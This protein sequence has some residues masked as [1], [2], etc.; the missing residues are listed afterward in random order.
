M[1]VVTLTAVVVRAEG[2]PTGATPHVRQLTSTEGNCSYLSPQLS[3]DG[4]WVS[5]VSVCPTADG[6]GQHHQIVRIA[7]A[8]GQVQV[9]TPPDFQ[10]LSPSV[11]VD[12]HRLVFISNADLA[13]PQNS[14]H[15]DQVFLFDARSGAYTQ[16]TGIQPSAMSRVVNN[17]RLSG[18]GG[19]VVFESNADLVKGENADGNL[20]LFLYEV[21]RGTLVQVTHTE[22]PARHQRPVLSRDGEIVAFLGV[23]PPFKKPHTGL[24]VWTRKTG[25]VR[26][27]SEMPAADT[28]AYT[29][30][31]IADRGHRVAFA[32]RF[33][34]L[35]ENPDR[36]TELYIL[37]LDTGL[38]RQLTHTLGCACANPWLAPDGMRILFVSNCQFGELNPKRHSNLFGIRVDTREI[39]RFTDSGAEAAV[40][41]PMADLTGRLAVLSIGAEFSGMVNPNRLLQIALVSLPPAE[42]LT[43]RPPTFVAADEVSAVVVSR[44]EEDVLYLASRRA[45]VLKSYDAGRQWRLMSFG[46]DSEI[47]TGLVEHPNEEGLLFA[48]TAQAGLFRTKNSGGLWL[49]INQ[50]LDDLRILTLAVDPVYPDVLYAQTPS[51][52]YWSLDQG[53]QWRPMS[54][55]AARAA[56]G[57]VPV[58]LGEASEGGVFSSTL[59]SLPGSTGRI[60]HLSESGLFLMKGEAG[61][62]WVQVHTPAPVRW[63]AVSPSGTLFIGAAEHVYRTDHPGQGW[64]QASGLPPKL[65]GPPV[66]GPRGRAY[67]AADGAL[68]RSDDHGLTWVRLAA[69]AGKAQLLVKEAPSGV[70]LAALDHGGLIISR[71]GGADWAPLRIP[72]P[73]PE[74]VQA[75]LFKTS[76]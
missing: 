2:V 50:G 29:Q 31:V 24:Y 48:G 68:Y 12:G 60:A 15:T 22:P 73:S 19:T 3:G 54:L 62:D 59:L 4:E 76:Q 51:G 36:N 25:E 8:S 55:P 16:I 35:G 58:S 45:G 11:S 38:A 5:A 57:A 70:V 47:V 49:P 61:E 18:D 71:N 13:P 67:A 7:R 23:H 41:V 42:P 43:D 75:V 52:F 39:T 33:D 1:G 69:F 32:G 66:F 40:E 6:M 10:S 28:G 46:L 74:G 20:E 63:V 27:V 72:V 34:L 26:R 65:A 9:L 44:H 21:G 56:S 14:A 53:D 64:E 37:D 17:P 30:L